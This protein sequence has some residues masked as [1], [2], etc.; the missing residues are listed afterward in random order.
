VDNPVGERRRDARFRHPL[1]AGTRALLRPG[2]VVTL[3]DLSAG[4][5]LIEG[6][7][8]LR[9]GSRVHL[10]L[11]TERRAFGIAA[12]VMRCA[13]ASLDARLGVQYRGALKFDHRCEALWE[14]SLPSADDVPPPALPADAGGGQAPRDGGP[15]DDAAGK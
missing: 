7:K 12:H 6:P 11:I 4:G 15:P 3:I 5:A 13:V 10:Q 1:I 2:Y 9:P 14:G 8:P